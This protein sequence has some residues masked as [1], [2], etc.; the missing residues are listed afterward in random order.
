MRAS[1]RSK[2]LVAA[3]DRA[4]GLAPSAV[5]RMKRAGVRPD[6]RADSVICRSS[7]GWKRIS[8]AAVRRS[9][10]ALLRS[11]GSGKTQPSLHRSTPHFGGLFW[12]A[13]S[14]TL[15][16]P[17]QYLAIRPTVLA[18]FARCPPLPRNSPAWGPACPRR[19][20]A[21]PPISLTPAE[22]QRLHRRRR[23]VGALVR[24]DFG[25]VGAGRP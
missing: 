17:Y 10:M 9:T 15:L 7:S 23:S 18:S 20:H 24:E 11:A 22:A 21:G 2:G 12:A 6:R 14:E 8:L 1:S 5:S 16:P 13:R 25:R 19:P 4:F 3:W